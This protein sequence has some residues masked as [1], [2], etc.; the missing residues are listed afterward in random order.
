MTSYLN[1][2]NIF[3]NELDVIDIKN[4]NNILENIITLS[5]YHS[6]IHLISYL[7]LKKMNNILL[8]IF[9]ITSFLSG[10]IEIINYNIK[11]NHNVFLVFG[12]IEIFLSMIMMTY[13][14]LKIAENQQDHYHYSNEYKIFI[15]EIG[16][17]N[18]LLNTNS[19]S[20]IY[21]NKI[22]YIKRFVD[23]FNKLIHDEPTIPDYILTKYK[24]KNIDI[25]L[26]NTNN[27]NN[28]NN[29]NTITSNYNKDNFVGDNIDDDNRFFEIPINNINVD[30]ISNSENQ[31]VHNRSKTTH[32]LNRSKTTHN[33]NGNNNRKI[34]KSLSI[35]DIDKI[36]KADIDNYNNFI[37][38]VKIKE[39]EEIFNSKVS[40][41]RSAFR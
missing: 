2:N 41:F 22:V 5:S 25:F 7:Y 27:T 6:K 9:I 19:Y 4:N 34:Y 14:N 30:E 20:F 15:N 38:N 35:M 13:K 36:K 21:K 3:Q 12:I 33:L 32:N 1:Q 31:I 8:F 24:I 37:N 39:E 18:Y 11:S 17:N 26:K 29:D 23:K 10:L 28:T 16:I 40:N